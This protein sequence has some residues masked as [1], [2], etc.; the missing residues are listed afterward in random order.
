[1]GKICKPQLRCDAAE[2]LVKQVVHG[3]MKL[4]DAAIQVREG[5][6]RG[7]TVS[8]RLPPGRDAT[9]PQVREALSGFLFEVDV[10]SN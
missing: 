3:Q 2:R 6:R 1:M 8:V 10:A 7:M 5:G 9:V 4:G